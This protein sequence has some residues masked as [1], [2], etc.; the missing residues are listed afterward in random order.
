MTLGDSTS[1]PL[2]SN[3]STAPVT[4]AETEELPEDGPGPRPSSWPALQQL[5]K[6]EDSHG[7]RRSL[8][9]RNGFDLRFYTPFS[10]FVLFR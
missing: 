8:R 3:C 1:L 6:K 7:Q 4:F 2:H 5:G 9:V 10:F